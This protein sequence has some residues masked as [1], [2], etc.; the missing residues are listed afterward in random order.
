[1]VR[2]LAEKWERGC[3]VGPLYTPSTAERVRWGGR[4]V[5]NWIVWQSLWQ[6]IFP[7][8]DNTTVVVL[9]LPT[10]SWSKRNI[11]LCKS[12][13]I[14]VIICTIICRT[15][16]TSFKFFQRDFIYRLHTYRLYM[17]PLVQTL[18]HCLLNRKEWKMLYYV[19][20]LVFVRLPAPILCLSENTFIF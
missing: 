13:L 15:Y 20:L 1:M 10:A 11:L 12:K 2:M 16:R 7:L 4:G 14:V 5:G 6:E 9:L 17:Q 18:G 3:A 8:Q 19:N